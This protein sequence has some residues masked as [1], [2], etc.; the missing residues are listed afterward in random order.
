MTDENS[1]NY[2]EFSYD[3]PNPAEGPA[4][5]TAESLGNI[6][7]EPAETFDSL[8]ARP[9]FVVAGLIIIAIAVVITT[10]LFQKV[11]FD[12]MVRQRM[13][14]S[15]KTAQLSS[16]QKE[17]AIRMQTGS[18]GKLMLYAGPPVAFLVM[19]CAGAGLYLLGTSALGGSMNYK[20]ALSVWVYSSFPPTVLAGIVGLVVLLLKSSDSIDPARPDKSLVQANLGILLG[21]GSSPVL[22]ALLS[23]IDLFAFYGL[24]LAAIGLRRM[25]R[26][27]SGSAWT[28]VLGIWVLGIVGKVGIAATFG[29]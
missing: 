21:S 18:L 15:P 13:E 2:S 22:S 27:S 17:Q 25:G 9:R 10:L 29:G 4:M 12:E 28:I 14:T 19:F 24:F 1:P 5:S 11:S 23:S 26:L 7:F 16:E 6:F 20:Q 3:D 8:R